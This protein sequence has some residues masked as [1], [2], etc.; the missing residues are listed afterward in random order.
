MDDYFVNSCNMEIQSYN[1]ELAIANLLF[2]KIF[3]N[4]TLQRLD[5]TS[6]NIVRNVKVPCVFGKRSRIL[7]NWENE[8]KRGSLTLPLIAISRTGYTRNPERL[9]NLHNE[10]L[11]EST[12]KYRNYNLLTP[13]PIDISYDV[14]VIAKYPS[15]IDQIASNFLVF[16]NNDIFVTCEH[17]KYYNVRLT[18]QIVLNDSINEEHPD[19]LDGTN[20]DIITTTFQF[21]FKT[22]L[23]GGTEKSYLASD[24][25][26]PDDGN[27]GTDTDG[28]IP[29]VNQIEFGFYPIPHSSNDIG[30][31]ISEIEPRLQDPNDLKPVEEIYVDRLLWNIETNTITRP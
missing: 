29:I 22:F 9:N 10:V 8:S 30:E 24:P 3:S 5:K 2:A 4:I 27:G 21:T 28:F 6:K 14:S 7:K 16:F 1:A 19:E 11:H 26:K 12:S 18:N 13:I 20:D 15:D 17:S 31:Y 25:N 23:F